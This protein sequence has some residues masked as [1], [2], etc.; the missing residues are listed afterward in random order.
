[1]SALPRDVK[2][3]IQEALQERGVDLSRILI[4]VHGEEVA[5]K[6]AVN[7]HEEKARAE[8]IVARLARRAHIR[9]D[10]AVALIYEAEEDVV[11][12][13]GV[14]S[15]PASDPPCWASRAGKTT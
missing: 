10:L 12:E 4:E 6:G 2:T 13:A 11:Y 1:M 8:Q 14:E 7:T 3:A 15:F 9:C 5:V